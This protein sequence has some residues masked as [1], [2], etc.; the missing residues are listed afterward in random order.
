[1]KCVPVC[2]T[3]E[4]LP[5]GEVVTAVF[6]SDAGHV[7][8]KRQLLVENT[9]F[10]RSSDAGTK[11]V[12]D[13]SLESP[14]LS[15]SDPTL[16]Q[17]PLNVPLSGLSLMGRV[18]YSDGSSLAM[19]VDG[20]K[21]AIFGLE[22][23]VATV[24]GQKLPLVLRYNLSVGEVAYGLSVGSERFISESFKAMTLPANGAYSVKLFGYPVWID[25]INGYR[26]EWFL[27]NLD[28]QTVYRATPHVTIN[29][30]TR[31]FDPIAYGINQRLSVSVNL[32][33]LNP[34]YTAYVH[35]Q[36]TDIVLLGQGTE[37]TTNW[38]IAFDPGQ[39]PVFG[40]NN[41]AVTTFI[42][43][44]LMK[45]R[46][47]LGETVKQTWLERIYYRSLP[48][49]D[50]NREI[51]APEPDYFALYVGNNVIE[52]PIEQWNSDLVVDRALADTDTLF[53]K[54]FK[55]T[56]DNDLQLSVIGLPIHQSN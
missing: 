25:A 43:Q 49:F 53:V 28:R 42:N 7:V 10:I 40:T 29:A 14:F 31:A 21:F 39:N 2:Y 8:S 41:K 55:R 11:Y 46:I 27:L 30:N 4:Q 20:S 33:D 9:A 18:H 16:I 34:S 23:Y 35:T 52:Y 51:R 37:L 24:V 1:M 45:V 17:Y 5:D 54:F 19:P 48:L 12:S 44:N 50:S 38:T 15:T 32:Q 6:Y 13:I 56:V 26:L 47:D 36:T 3:S 22:N